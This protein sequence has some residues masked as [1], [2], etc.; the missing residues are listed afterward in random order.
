MKV[1]VHVLDTGT[2]IRIHQPGAS[3]R[4]IRV[5]LGRVAGSGLTDPAYDLNHER[6]QR[7]RADC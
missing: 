3:E 6:H 1:S 4:G 2:H 5:V 7:E